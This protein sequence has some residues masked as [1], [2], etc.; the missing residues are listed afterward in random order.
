MFLREKG[1]DTFN[2]DGIHF[3]WFLRFGAYCFFGIIIMTALNNI[4]IGIMSNTYDYYQER[5]SRMLVRLRASVALDYAL[6][7]GFPT[8][9]KIL[10]FATDAPRE[11][12]EEQ[13]GQDES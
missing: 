13:S 5:T 8:E 1:R 9:Q 10:W 11:G 7:T 6:L 4:F 12:N 2:E 3:E